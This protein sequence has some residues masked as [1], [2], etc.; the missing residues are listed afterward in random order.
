MGWKMKV[1]V[2]GIGP[3]YLIQGIWSEVLVRGIWSVVLVRGIWSKVLVQGI[4]K[5]LKLYKEEKIIRPKGASIEY[6]MKC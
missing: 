5:G 2:Q 3:R 4:E 1:L 6:L